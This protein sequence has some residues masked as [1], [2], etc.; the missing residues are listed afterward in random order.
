MFFKSET[1]VFSL[2]QTS[3]D[4]PSG[5]VSELFEELFCYLL[6]Y[7][8]YREEVDF[9]SNDSRYTVT[10]N[11]VDATMAYTYNMRLG[12]LIGNGFSLR[13]SM[14]H[15]N[16]HLNDREQRF[17]RALDQLFQPDQSRYYDIDGMLFL[18]IAKTYQFCDAM[19]AIAHYAA[20]A[21]GQRY[22]PAPA[23][24]PKLSISAF[25]NIHLDSDCPV[26]VSVPLLRYGAILERGD[27][28]TAL[29]ALMS[30]QID[31]LLTREY[32][33][34]ALL[35]QVAQFT[36]ATDSMPPMALTIPRYAVSLK[37]QAMTDI[38]DRITPFAI[39]AFYKRFLY[40]ADYRLSIL[41]REQLD[42]IFNVMMVRSGISPADH[43]LYPDSCYGKLCY[44]TS[45]TGK[46]RALPTVIR[47]ALESLD[48]S[49]PDDGLND[50]SQA[51]GDADEDPDAASADT[52]APPTDDDA[53]ASDSNDLS[54]V[55]G[56]MPSDSG[57]DGVS[58]DGTPASGPEEEDALISFRTGGEGVNADLYR[59]AVIALNDRLQ[60][61]DSVPVSSDVKEA[62]RHWVNGF[63]YRTSFDTT[64]A[65]IASLKLQSYVKYV[66]TKG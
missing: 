40:G 46:T 31:D 36:F 60:K 32:P 2:E 3:N 19:T 43:L 51:S 59:A 10:G 34:E 65:R 44:V 54:S 25:G 45:V 29:W 53:S 1:K 18:D 13:L 56:E 37:M 22:D 64:V 5:R 47:Y 12:S 11:N 49:P 41:H 39:S 48:A 20:V 38:P 24:L 35:D 42:F 15:R 8:L 9:I 21:F 66:S 58:P 62:L 4:G 52:D 28:V 63:L 6:L 30:A 57:A 33:G 17:C 27:R 7:G 14:L 55:D 23:Q 16:P 26:Q 61:D 50:S